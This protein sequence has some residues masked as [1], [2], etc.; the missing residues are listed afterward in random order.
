MMI[1]QADL[2]SNPAVI[3]IYFQSTRC[4]ATNNKELNTKTNNKPRGVEGFPD[5]RK[6]SSSSFQKTFIDFRGTGRTPS[7]AEFG[8]CVTLANFGP[9]CIVMS[10]FC[11]LF[12]SW[13]RS[14]MR[15]YC[16]PFL[17]SKEEKDLKEY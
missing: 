3:T 10:R 4:D 13:A 6:S 7:H 15:R 2:P 8:S 14:W 1:C 16:G 9:P 5:R 12:D 17:K 11:Q